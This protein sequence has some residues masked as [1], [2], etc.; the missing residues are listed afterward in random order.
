MFYAE[1][2]YLKLPKRIMALIMVITL[3][4]L[5]YS[6]AEKKLRKAMAEQSLTIGDQ[7]ATQQR[8]LRSA[9]F[10]KSMNPYW[11]SMSSNQTG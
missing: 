7:N 8:S 11:Y 6:L 4:L 2:P 1:S 10:F 5:V 9:G 3:S